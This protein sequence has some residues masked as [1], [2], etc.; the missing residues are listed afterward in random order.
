MIRGADFDS[1][2]LLRIVV[3]LAHVRDSRKEQ[4]KREGERAFVEPLRPR[5]ELQSAVWRNADVYVHREVLMGAE[6]VDD[7]SALLAVD[8]LGIKA[9]SFGG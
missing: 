6:V 2:A 7:T 4:R 1:K 5:P 9:A 8:H 3:P